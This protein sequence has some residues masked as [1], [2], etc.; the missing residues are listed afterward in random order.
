MQT[1]SKEPQESSTSGK[2]KKCCG[3]LQLGRTPARPLSSGRTPGPRSSPSSQPASGRPTER[4]NV[5][6]TPSSSKRRGAPREP[7][8]RPNPRTRATGPRGNPHSPRPG[9]AGGWGRLARQGAQARAPG[10]ARRAGETGPAG[11]VWGCP[12]RGG[13]PGR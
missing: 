7:Q 12:G 9:Q 6:G 11:R 3:I 1:G 4:K 8:T 2:E 10:A 13:G 5:W